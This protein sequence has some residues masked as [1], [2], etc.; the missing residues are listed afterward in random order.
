MDP[1]GKIKKPKLYSSQANRGNALELLIEIASRHYRMK[2]LARLD[3]AAT[4]TKNIRGRLVYAEKSTV[5]FYGTVKG[6][7]S[8]Y[9][10]AK[11]TR[12][13]TSFPLKNIK[14]HQTDF[15]QE[16]AELGAAVFFLI[17]FAE[18]KEFYYL[19]YSIA[20]QYIDEAAEGGRKSIPYDDF[21]A[22]PAIQEIKGAPGILLDF[23]APIREG[24][25]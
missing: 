7:R 24:K 14:D 11:S 21:R 5:D 16:Q 20:R 2:R 25:A 18:Q 8:V 3:K 15:L 13:K 23:L 17:E 22:N 6:G 12:N 4:P 10:D 9:F 19:P 1:S